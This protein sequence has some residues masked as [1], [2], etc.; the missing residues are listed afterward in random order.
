MTLKMPSTLDDS[1]ATAATADTEPPDTDQDPELL[2]EVLRELAR[3]EASFPPFAS[4]HEGYALLLEEVDQ[5]WT[6][7][8]R[9]PNSRSVGGMRREAV[10]V[11]AMALRIVRDCC[12]RQGA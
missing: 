1:I 3:G 8:K 11:A 7:V 5:L 4:A 6:E 12:D 9:R 10:Q 2:R